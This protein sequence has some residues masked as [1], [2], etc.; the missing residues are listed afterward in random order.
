MSTKLAA[1]AESAAGV[2]AVT[3]VREFNRFYT[4]VLGLLREG[5]LDTPYSLT[6]ARVI[7]E[8]GRADHAEVAALRAWLDIDRGYLSRILA[9]FEADGLVT[10]QR[11]ASDG[12]RQ[13]IGLTSR[14]RSAF[15][16]LDSRS[17]G[18]ISA[19]LSERSPADQRRL[20][21]AM[22]TI[23]EVIEGPARP[24]DFA[25]REPE[26]GDLGWVVQV[27]G[28]LYAR[29]YGWDADFEALVARIMAD[30]AAG[31]DPQRERGWIA[32]AGGLPAGCIFCVRKSDTTA[33][34][35]LL[36]VEPWARG[37]GIGERLVA[38]CIVFARA[39]G[40]AEIVLWTQDVLAA[41]RRIY[42]RAGFQ[43]VEEGRHHSFGHDLVEQ[44]WRLA[45]G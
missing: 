36:L 9:R 20:T 3:A 24:P 6:E 12:R 17:T 45:L 40:Y 44:T 37:A 7:F 16:M 2:P 5:L 14:G 34:L 39:S 43:L 30:Y 33:Q 1:S 18:Q 31:H 4:N 41:A 32:E 29:D 35:R 26:P 8:L 23:R 27:H 11:S 42:Q 22:A 13:V 28:A 15:R 38:E 25:L 10:R 21:A 19:L